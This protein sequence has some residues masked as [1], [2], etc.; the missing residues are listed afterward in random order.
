MPRLAILLGASNAALAILLG[1]FAAHA[2]HNSWPENRY[3]TFQIAVDYHLYH[4]LGLIVVGILITQRASSRLLEVAAALM[5]AGIV[6]FCGS[7]YLLS[8]TEVT[9]L[10]MVTPFGGTAFI[11]SWILVMIA[12]LSKKQIGEERTDCS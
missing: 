2:L 3:S 9:W 12:H 1:A 11:G 10:G 4:A 5:L 8:F 7:L 6:L